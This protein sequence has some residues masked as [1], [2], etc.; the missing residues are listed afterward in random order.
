VVCGMWRGHTVVIPRTAGNGT[1]ARLNGRSTHYT[2]FAVGYVRPTP[3]P[4]LSG[5]GANAEVFTSVPRR[6]RNH[7][8]GWHR[9]GHWRLADQQA[10]HWIA[11]DAVS[12]LSLK[13]VSQKRKG[14]LLCT[15]SSAPSA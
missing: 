13:G 5:R 6:V 8:S 2:D 10:R 7:A 1:P 11:C 15:A 3:N 9:Y 4:A 12:G 14:R